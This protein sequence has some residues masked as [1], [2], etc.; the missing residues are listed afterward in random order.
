MK[1]ILLYAHRIRSA[2]QLGVTQMVSGHTAANTTFDIKIN[3]TNRS[4][5]SDENG[6]FEL[7]LAGVVLTS[8]RKM[9]AGQTSLTDVTLDIDTSQV[10][11]FLS[12]FNMSHGLK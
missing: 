7:G 2:S 11:E 4:V 10:T 9:F 5:T 3:G 1:S 12:V 6:Y 8:L